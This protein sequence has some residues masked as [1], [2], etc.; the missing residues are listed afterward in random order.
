MRRKI[1]TIGTLAA[2]AW[3]AASSPAMA[4]YSGW[5]TQLGV[6]GDGCYAYTTYTSNIVTPHIWEQAGNPGFT[7]ILSVVHVGFDGNNNLVYENSWG[8]QST[9]ARSQAIDGPSWYYGP[10][11]GNGWMC[12]R[13]YV[14]DGRGD[15]GNHGNFREVC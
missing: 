14:D 12:V 11:D 5:D 9:T 4:A 3:F 1:A 8:P 6:P 13:I 10:W 7:C 2:A 15:Q